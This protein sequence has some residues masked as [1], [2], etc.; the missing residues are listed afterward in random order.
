MS[1]RVSLRAQAL[2][3]QFASV[4]LFENVQLELSAGWTG[5][6][7]ENGA[8]KTTL[9]RVLAE[10]L[11]PDSGVVQRIPA[12]ARVIRV[13]QRQDRCTGEVRAFAEA[14]DA[15]AWR[16]RGELRLEP[17]SLPRWSTLSGGERKRWQVGA[18]LGSEPEVLLLDE[19]TTF[20]DAEGVR[21][22]VSAL[23]RHRG[24]GVVVSHDR[25]LLDALTV[26]TLFVSGGEVE[27]R[28]GSYSDASAQRDAERESVRAERAQL[29]R[30]QQK[31]HRALVQAAEQLRGATASRSTGKRMKNR[32]DSDARTLVADGRAANAERAHAQRANAA[33]RK[34]ERSE[35]ELSQ[36]RIIEEPPP[37]LHLPSAR[38]PK[39]VLLIHDRD[40]VEVEGRTLIT[41]ARVQLGR[42]DRVAL[43]G[44]NGSGKTTLVRALLEGSTVPSEKLFVLPQDLSEEDARDAVEQVRDLPR[45][46]RGRI[47]ALV[48]AL[49]ADP[50]RLLRTESPS[51]GEARKL[52]LGQ[53]LV[54]AAWA[55]VLDEPTQHLDL[56]SVERL[57]RA[58]AEYDGALL[59][60][61]HDEALARGC[62]SSRWT[63]E[64]GVLEVRSWDDPD[65]FHAGPPSGT[66]HR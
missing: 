13:D 21:W 27:L 65:C 35:Q 19:P 29:A 50:E 30:D 64:H 34:L 60:I 20:L 58:L 38:A 37:E 4:S 8:G 47:L 25:A 53:A 14:Q 6:V 15:L 22:L 1:S 66:A 32:Y 55:L 43:M 44:P 3:V 7:G 31:R 36:Q 11:S 56:P 51:P 26:R 10:E 63:I 23:Q 12:D 28:T 40:I 39:P 2:G 18:A 54:N 61:T 52:L 49:G 17:E 9:L 16:I 24:V 57:E 62:T 46:E 42:S 45:E 41:G 5:V 33:K 59:M 48:G